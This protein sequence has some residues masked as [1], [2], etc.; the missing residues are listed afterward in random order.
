MN[1]ILGNDIGR[2]RLCSED[3]RDRLLRRVTLLDLKILIDR[4]KRVHLL[5]LI[6]MQTLYLHIEDAVLT[7]GNPLRPL[8]IV[9]QIDLV[10]VLDFADLCQNLFVM[11]ELHQTFQLRRIFFEFRSDQLLDQV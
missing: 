11:L 1:D 10:H 6:L 8:Q 3:H 7:Q 2:C 5:P 9:N 4:V